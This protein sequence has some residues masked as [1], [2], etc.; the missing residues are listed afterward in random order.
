M[1]YM[2]AC[3][4]CNRWLRRP[5]S[6]EGVLECPACGP[7]VYLGSRDLQV[8]TEHPAPEEAERESPGEAIQTALPWLAK[9]VAPLLGGKERAA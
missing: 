4:I 2:Q 6:P 9:L 5:D 1:P 3:P 8:T 7:V